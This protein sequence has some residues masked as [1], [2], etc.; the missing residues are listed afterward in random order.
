MNMAEQKKRKSLGS[1]VITE[2]LPDPG[3]HA[4]V[5]LFHDNE[6]SLMGSSLL[7]GFSFVATML[8]P[9]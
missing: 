1:E 6:Y 8:I 2:R 4:S 3:S 7:I 5:L 9:K